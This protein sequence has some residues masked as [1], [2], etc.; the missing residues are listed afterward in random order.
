[1]NVDELSPS[2]VKR[3]LSY[4]IASVDSDWK[5]PIAKELFTVRNKELIIEGFSDREI[6]MIFDYICT[7]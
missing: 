3:K 6:E 2:I 4:K 5:V 1:M 7:E